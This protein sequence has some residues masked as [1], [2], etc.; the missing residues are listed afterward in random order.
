MFLQLL[1]KLKS[2][3]LFSPY[4]VIL[5]S[6]NKYR[7]PTTFLRRILGQTQTRFGPTMNT[8]DPTMDMWSYYQYRS[9]ILAPKWCSGPCCSVG[10]FHSLVLFLQQL[11]TST[12][13]G[14]FLRRL[15][16]PVRV[17][18]TDMCCDL[19]TIMAKVD[20]G[21]VVSSVLR[22]NTTLGEWAFLL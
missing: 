2:H 18:T 1:L 11:Q 21:G 3:V 9:R 17:P 6:Y 8:G 13:V 16:T 19:G 10:L 20:L 7:V 14:G 15:W 22:K 5:H 12:R 4:K